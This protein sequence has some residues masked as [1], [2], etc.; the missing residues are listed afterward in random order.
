M[1]FCE[2]SDDILLVAVD[3]ASAHGDADWQNHGSSSDWR[4][5]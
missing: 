5:W 2:V 4:C 1:F 3:P